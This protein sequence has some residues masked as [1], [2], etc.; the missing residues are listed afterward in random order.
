[1]SE[2]PEPMPTEPLKEPAQSS[3]DL[4]VQGDTCLNCE[5]PVEAAFCPQCGQS[6]RD[7]RISFKSL[8]HDFMGDVF[9]FDS[10]LFRTL[11][12]LFIKPGALTESF[13]LGHRVRFVPPLR[14]FIF[15]SL[16]FFVTIHYSMPIN[17]DIVIK[18]DAETTEQG[19]DDPNKPTDQATDNQDPDTEQPNPAS[20]AKNKKHKFNVDTGLEGNDTFLGRKI[21]EL[22]KRQE[23]RFEHLDEDEAARLFVNQLFRVLSKALLLIMPLFALF[24]KLLYIRRDPFYL[25]HLIFAFHYHAFLFVFITCVIIFNLIFDGTWVVV[26]TVLSCIFVPQVYM[27]LSLKRVYQQ[28]W[29]RTLVKYF[30]L[31]TCYFGTM[32]PFA[33]IIALLAFLTA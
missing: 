1:M 25:D 15:S 28:G 22:V 4:P 14:L 33:S 5:H 9:T 16:I 20:P 30:L 3:E 29:I 13:M 19:V 6:T 11:K 8:A 7:L 12:P 24:L 2:A 18:T 23:A 31:M 26:S 10:K 27:Y 32:I 21:N 17:R